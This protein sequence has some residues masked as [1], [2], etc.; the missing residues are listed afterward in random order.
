M[1]ANVNFWTR[2]RT[3]IE[4]PLKCTFPMPAEASREMPHTELSLKSFS[5][6]GRRAFFPLSC[7]TATPNNSDQ[8]FSQLQKIRLRR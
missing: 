4:N 8:P 6:L 5:R 3:I 7:I 2:Y 1:R